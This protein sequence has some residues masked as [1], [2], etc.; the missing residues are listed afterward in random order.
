MCAWNQ[1]SRSYSVLTSQ[2]ERR[3]E[4]WV[5]HWERLRAEKEPGGLSRRHFCSF[6]FKRKN[7][8]KPDH[9]WIQTSPSSGC[10][11]APFGS[12]ASTGWT[13]GRLQQKQIRWWVCPPPSRLV[14][15]SPARPSPDRNVRQKLQACRSPPPVDWSLVP[16]C[17]YWSLVP[18]WNL[19]RPQVFPWATVGSWEVTLQQTPNIWPL[20]FTLTTNL[21]L[22]TA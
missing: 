21:K 18:N 1:T 10:C 15:I 3:A 13:A 5:A 6:H 12:K 8:T 20:Y 16:N 2:G 11:C 19:T 9:V 7:K 4:S 17:V 22:N 14:L